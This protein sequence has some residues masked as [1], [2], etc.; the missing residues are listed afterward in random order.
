MAFS[1]SGASYFSIPKYY[2]ESGSWYNRTIDAFG[3]GFERVFRLCKDTP[4]QYHNNQF[5]FT[6]EFLRDQN[7]TINDSINDPIN[8]LS[9]S[10][11]ALLTLIISG[12]ARNKQE[13]SSQIKKSPATIQRYISHLTEMGIIKREGSNKNG[14]WVIIK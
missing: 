10:E 8:N 3:T 9:D 14:R 1:K 2:R 7:E 12:R 6:F 13:F 11:K 4:Y 5:G